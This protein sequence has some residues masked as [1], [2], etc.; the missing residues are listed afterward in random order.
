MNAKEYL[1]YLIN[2]KKEQFSIDIQLSEL[3]LLQ[4]M[5]LLDEMQ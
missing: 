2:T 5:M 3:V 4:A 1:Q